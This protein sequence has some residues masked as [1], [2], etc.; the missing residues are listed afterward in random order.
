MVV[1]TRAIA[2]VGLGILGLAAL[3]GPTFGQQ[4]ADPAVRKAATQTPASAP[5]PPTPVTVGYV[6]V[7]AVFKNY[8]KVKVNAEEFRA[9]VM[10]KKNELMKVMAEAQQESETLAKL[11]PGSVDFK[12][13]E[14]RITHLKA[15]H[16]ASREQYEREFTLRESEMLATLYKEVQSMVARI[17]KF[18][19]FLY[20]MKVSNEPVT[21][22]NPNSAM[23]AIER[24]VVYADPRND[25]TNDVVY[26]LNRE[27]KASGGAAPKGTAPAAAGAPAT[28][29]PAPAQATPSGN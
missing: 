15:Q 28:P 29:S 3:V 12:K 22:S 21:G 11:T 9:A 5:P 14:D 24:A 27:Y 1:S 25:I 6:D 19:G 10:A 18:R 17:A 13:H 26:Y 16:E 7:S 4:P 23:M 2:A 20:V 8:D